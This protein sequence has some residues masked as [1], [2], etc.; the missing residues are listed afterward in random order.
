MATTQINGTQIR[1]GAITDAKVAAGAAIAT[2]KLALNGT[3]ILKDGSV[4]H[5]GDQSMGNFKLTNVATPVSTTDAA[6]KAY[7][8]TQIANLNSLFDSKGSARAATTSNITVSNPAT[9]S[10]DGVT[11]S[12]GDRLLLR[13][14][15]A[16]AENGIYTFNGSGSALTRVTDMDAWG[17]V[18]GAFVIVEEGTTYADTLW[19][20]TSNQGGTLG[21]TA[22]TWTQITAGSGLTGSNFVD[23]ETPSGSINGSNTT[24]TLANTPIAGT[25]KLFLNGQRL[26]AGAGNDYTISSATITMAT[27]PVSGDVLIADYRK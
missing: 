15:S 13:A 19:L 7:V 4:A 12:N 17:E 16:P 6:N 21:T 14:Q 22:I 5:T 2:S 1:D 23:S 24:F 18:P 10:F 8:D 25:V 20:C 27:A 9:A 11:L 3:I 26:N